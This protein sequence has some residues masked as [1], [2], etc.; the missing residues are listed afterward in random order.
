MNLQQDDDNEK[1]ISSEPITKDLDFLINTSYPTKKDYSKYREIFSTDWK[2]DEFYSNSW[3]SEN[4]GIKRIEL[5]GE[6]SSLKKQLKIAY[7]EL[8]QAKSDKEEKI[9]EFKTLEEKL[10]SKEKI[11]HIIPRICEEARDL[12]LSQED[13]RSSF[14]DG[15]SCEA[16]VISIDIR[17]STELMLKARRPELFS[18]FITELSQKLSDAIL[19]NFGIFDK[20]TG[21]GILAFF[22]KFYSGEQSIV[23]ALKAA[24]ECHKIF[25]E[26][27]ENSKE[28]FNVFIKDVGLGIG[29][30]Y[31]DVTLVNTR[32]ELTVV[33]IPVV[34]ACRM[35]GA[36]A[37][38]TLLNQPAKE[39][40]NRLGKNYIK[41]TESEI[42]IKNE[43]I[44]LAYTIE[45]HESFLTEK[46]DWLK[47]L[48]NSSEELEPESN[49]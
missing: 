39:E 30:D 2:S 6:I 10:K 8:K 48:I 5:E 31:G 11:S 13:F 45:L 21:D 40:I 1:K 46:P 44:A 26:H 25:K 14:Q 35:G 37:G 24:E 28:C 17:R 4:S 16:V 15:E 7:N 42:N 43:G 22:P 34:Y 19:K 20:F 29:I 32:N 36:K 3:L 9:T 49:V 47:N 33:G 12:L 41:V 23:H 18:K 38:Q 27:Y